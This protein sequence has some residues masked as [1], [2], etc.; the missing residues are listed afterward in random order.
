MPARISYALIA[1][2]RATEWLTATCLLAFALTLSLPGETLAGS[3]FRT[4]KELGFDDAMLAAPMALIAAIR[5]AALYI[6]GNW[7]RSPLARMLGAIVGAAVFGMLGA[8]FGWPFLE[9]A[10]I[11]PE[12]Q[13]AS[14]GAATYTVL[15][16]FDALAAYR[17]AADLELAKRTARF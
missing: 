8:A 13:A 14:T 15:A 4:F 10:L 11:G 2:G 3:G 6:N 1:H 7:R 16:L 12:A 5:L 9:G 17:S